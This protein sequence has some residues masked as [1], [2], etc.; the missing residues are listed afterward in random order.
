MKS[1]HHVSIVAH[2]PFTTSNAVGVV[3]WKEHAGAGG[4]GRL[5]PSSMIATD[6]SDESGVMAGHASNASSV[7]T[8]GV[9]SSRGSEESGRSGCGVL[10]LQAEAIVSVQA[11]AATTEAI[12]PGR[13]ATVCRVGAPLASKP[14]VMVATGM[15]RRWTE[16]ARL[17]C[18]VAAI[19]CSLSSRALAQAPDAPVSYQFSNQQLRV[20]Q[21]DFAGVIDLGCEPRAALRWRDIVYVACGTAGVVQIDI[22]HVL[23]PRIVGVSPVD[24]SATDVSLRGKGVWVEASKPDSAEAMAP[25]TP[26]TLVLAPTPPE[27]PAVVEP[28]AVPRK[29]SIIA[30]DRRS[31]FEGFIGVAGLLGVQG[32]AGVGGLLGQASVTYRAPWPIMV[33]AELAPFGFVGPR[34]DTTGSSSTL[35][36]SSSTTEGVA[37]VSAG[38]VLAGLDTHYFE[39]GVGG[40]GATVNEPPATRT[41]IFVPGPF[42]GSSPPPTP[43]TTSPLFL[44]SMRV[45]AHDGLAFELLTSILTADSVR[46]GAIRTTFQIP[47]SATMMLLLRG[48]GGNIGYWYSDLGLRGLLRGDGGHG[49]VAL[50]GWFGA[51]H[52]GLD[53]CS[54][55]PDPP[56]T[57]ACNTA[58][59]T[60]PSLGFGLEWRP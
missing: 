17:A 35:G 33:R 55:N 4:P 44:T 23:A 14:R 9:A 54:A 20:T 29:P 24:G 27:Q 46:L 48:G 50:V 49:T 13:I 47:L 59:V 39:L 19:A 37:V 15:R 7:S 51:A 56:F 42:G 60:G 25:A 43:S 1:I 41:T 36:A 45:G 52:V 12:G 57:K 10:L 5:P 34:I 40:G 28:P 16:P 2:E 38:H 3:L 26:F 22:T 53:V 18:V 30:P 21:G 11:Q 31:G 58:S 8:S 32:T 6:P